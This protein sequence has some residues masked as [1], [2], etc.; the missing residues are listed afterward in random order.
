MVGP[1]NF[2]SLQPAAWAALFRH[3]QL[4]GLAPE[5][6]RHFIVAC[7]AGHFIFHLAT[8]ASLPVH[9]QFASNG[10]E[11][12]PLFNRKQKLRIYGYPPY[13]TV[14]GGD[15]KRLFG[16]EDEGSNA[17]R[18]Y[19]GHF[20]YPSRH[21]GLVQLQNINA[22]AAQEPHRQAALPCFPFRAAKKDARGHAF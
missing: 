13:F 2:F 10:L 3:Q 18:R 15:E 1:S 9:S 5:G 6:Q 4:T 17:F 11:L 7:L 16:T 21:P 20:Q 14:I 22:L 8:V 12:P 19:V